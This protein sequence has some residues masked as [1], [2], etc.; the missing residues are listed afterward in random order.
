MASKQY[1]NR[2]DGSKKGTGYLGIFT[3]SNGEDVTEYSVGVNI[4]GQDIDVPTLVPT[5]TGAEVQEVIKASEEG[6]FPSDT[7]IRKAQEYATQ[8]L[9]SGLPVFATPKD[10]KASRKARSSLGIK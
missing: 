10:E 3:N 6:R 9:E 7:V 4:Y 5:L 1:G 8:R 2:S